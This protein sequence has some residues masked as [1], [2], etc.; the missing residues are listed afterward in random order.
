MVTSFP[1][2]INILT[3]VQEKYDGGG[4]ILGSTAMMN[5]LVYSHHEKKSRVFMLEFS[6]SILCAVWQRLINCSA[7]GS[8][9]P[10]EPHMLWAHR[11][12]HECVCV[13][14]CVSVCLCVCVSVCL[15]VCV[16]ASVWLLSLER[17]Y[18][19]L[20]LLLGDFLLGLDFSTIYLFLQTLMPN[21]H[22]Y[23][24]HAT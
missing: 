14:V 13:C 16:R 17:S 8:A 7:G 19:I 5:L 4:G 22:Y 2:N 24:Y 21:C 20:Q 9:I 18:S 11:I 3:K 15:C 6:C 1:C 10:P 23:H 12:L